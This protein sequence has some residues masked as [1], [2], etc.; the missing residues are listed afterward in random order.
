MKVAIG[1]KEFFNVE[2]QTCAVCDMIIKM[3]SDNT[4]EENRYERI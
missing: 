2:L 1:E 4:S 3:T